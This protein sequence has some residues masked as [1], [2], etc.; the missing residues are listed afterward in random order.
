LREA[1]QQVANMRAAFPGCASRR[2]VSDGIAGPS[3]TPKA[4]S[5][6]MFPLRSG[7]LAARRTEGRRQGTMRARL[8]LTDTIKHGRGL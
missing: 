5:P 6:R 4:N 7:W 2:C 3:L 1:E 8:A